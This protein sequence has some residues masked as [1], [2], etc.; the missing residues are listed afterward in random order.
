MSFSWDR[1]QDRQ[2]SMHGR[3][4]AESM[5]SIN[6][7]RME[8]QALRAVLLHVLASLAQGEEVALHQD[9]VRGFLDLPEDV[10]PEQALDRLLRFQARVVGKVSCPE[11]GAT[12]QDREGIH[13]EVC[14]WCG[15]TLQTER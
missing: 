7:M 12:I 2:I 8:I 11:C 4:M 9:P 10:T 14:Q 15:S 6:E 5:R 13:D 1:M 3:D